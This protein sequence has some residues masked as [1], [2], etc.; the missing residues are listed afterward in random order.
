MLKCLIASMVVALAVVASAPMAI[1][2]K[3]DDKAEAK[4]F[5]RAGEQAFEAGQYQMAAQ[6]FEEAYRRFPSPAI[7]FSAAQALRLQYFVDKE[8]RNLKR[9]VELYRAYLEEVKSG[10]RRADAA[11]NLAELEPI[12]QRIESS[13][14]IDMTAAAPVTKLLVTAQVKS[15]KAQVGDDEARGVPVAKEVAP[16][17]YRIRIEADG[18]FPYD[19]SVEVFEG[20]YRAVEV[21]LKAK[22][23]K[24]TLAGIE[25]G[26][27]VLVDGRFVGRTPRKEPL[28]IPA[29]PHR[30]TILARGHHAISREI[31]VGRGEQK[32]VKAELRTTWQRKA[33]WGVLGLSAASFVTAGVYWGFAA[34]EQK[35]ARD[36]LDKLDREAL[37][38]AESREYQDH[39]DNRNSYRTGALFFGGVGLA[40][41]AAGA[42]MYYLDTPEAGEQGAPIITPTAGPDQVGVGVSGRF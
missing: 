11:A 25:S 42:L 3:A 35:Q 4:R 17:K 36:L 1:A 12:L 26:A 2:Q 10:G 19:E 9:S 14:S 41:G 23:A 28:E 24:L 16:G 5:F 27:R 20:Q 15:A 31:S 8:P 13:E 32:E 34:N 37:T 29:G 6:A 38:L 7:A 39:V 30:V 40:V 18:Y 22:P 33:S 21:T